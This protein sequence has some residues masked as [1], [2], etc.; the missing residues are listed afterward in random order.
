[1][2]FNPGHVVVL[3]IVIALVVPALLQVWWRSGLPVLGKS[4]WTLVIAFLVGF[5]PLLWYCW[6]LPTRLM[7]HHSARG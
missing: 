7:Q 3:L 1:M 6:W 4:V 2:P 5:G